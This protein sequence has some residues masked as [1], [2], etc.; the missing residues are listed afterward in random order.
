[1]ATTTPTLT[2]KDVMIDRFQRGR[3]AL[4]AAGVDWVDRLR[5]EALAHFDRLGI[6]T[7]R[8][9]D[10]RFTPV[11]RLAAF[12]PEPASAATAAPVESLAEFLHDDMRGSRLVFA[13]GVF[14]PALSN[15]DTLPEGVRMMTLAEALTRYAEIVRPHLARHAE[16]AEHA[17]TALNTA[18]MGDGAFLY[19]ADGAVLEDPLHV[20]YLA[21]GDRPVAVHPRTL[22]LAGRASQATL[23]ETF[24]GTGADLYFQ[25]GVTEIVLAE[26]AHVD[27]IKLQRE[28]LGAFHVHTLQVHQ[29]RSSNFR[30]HSITL[31]AA[32]SRNDVNI[33]LAGEGIE[34]TLKGLYMVN[35]AQHT[36]TH[37]RLDHAKP[38]CHSYEL[39]KGILDERA[40]GVFTGKILVRQDAQKT[41]AYQSNKALLLSDAAAVNTQPQ[42]EIFADDVKCSHGATIGQL[43]ADSEFYLRTRGID[44][45]TARGM[46]TYAFANDVLEQIRVVPIRAQLERAVAEKFHGRAIAE[47]LT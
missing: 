3:A 11:D 42:L 1:M 34:T 47:V 5:G 2:L 32:F 29:E 35:G 37:S 9:E 43:D 13:N 45:D 20:L 18:W 21:G 8:D 33:V 44:A 23:V 41:D 31:G 12:T 36:D 30:T 17:F 38:H 19:I 6:P 46:L 25:N 26:D 40:T 27:H 22:V 39:Y 10:W 15:V 16:F 4:P 14:Q 28:S 24:A 7:R